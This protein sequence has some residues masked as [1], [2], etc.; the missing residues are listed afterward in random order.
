[1][2]LDAVPAHRA[3]DRLFGDGDLLVADGDAVD[4]DAVRG[5]SPYLDRDLRDVLDAVA[6]HANSLGTLHV[7]LP[8]IVDGD[9]LF[10]DHRLPAVF[11]HVQQLVSIDR[12]FLIGLHRDELDV[13]APEHDA[14]PEQCA[15]V[16]VIRVRPP[17]RTQNAK[18]NAAAADLDLSDEDDRRLTEASD[19]FNPKGGPA[20]YAD[21]LKARVR[22]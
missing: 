14:A 2:I 5:E 12:L 1:M 13:L 20:A 10:S 22:R 18:A 11:V 8:L 17:R 3:G 16:V 9:G 15:D 21:L 6:G 4:D 7:V 19:R